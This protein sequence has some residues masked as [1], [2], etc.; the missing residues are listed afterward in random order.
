MSSRRLQLAWSAL[1]G[2]SA[3]TALAI[4]AVPRK[5]E[6]VPK[7]APRPLAEL[8][9]PP[10]VEDEPMR[11]SAPLP[12][13]ESAERSAGEPVLVAP[14]HARRVPAAVTTVPDARRA[15]VDVLE[16]ARGLAP[17]ALADAAVA[18]GPE[19]VPSLLEGILGRGQWP[20]GEH[21]PTGDLRVE[22][23]RDAWSRYEPA[24]RARALV[25]CSAATRDERRVLVEL[26]GELGGELALRTVLR[27]AREFDG[28]DLARAF[29]C[30][31]VERALALAL[32]S[33]R[34]GERQLEPM[35][36]ELP[37][38]LASA[39]VRAWSLSGDMRG[40]ALAARALGHDAALDLEIL[41]ALAQPAC[42]ARAA[43]GER[44]LEGLRG[45]LR[46]ADPRL[47]RCA[48]A[49]LGNARD[50]RSVEVLV[51]TL[52]DVD[53]LVRGAARESLRAITGRDLG[54]DAQAWDSWSAERREWLEVVQPRELERSRGSDCGAAMEALEALLA[55]AD[56][57]DELVSGL[58]PL[59]EGSA[60]ENV[61]ERV[62]SALLDIG[63][64]RALALAQR[65]EK[66][67]VGTD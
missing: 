22:A 17:S 3:F 20:E 61:A 14:V 27:L 28:A 18:L 51:A 26:A 36:E 19:L 64:A 15:L 33:S 4:V 35:L 54:G 12:A 1:V 16:G 32:G 57:R 34:A 13:V 38:P 50:T 39:L 7:P 29:V 66:P 53:A 24:L 5:G 56:T 52:E 40:P 47:R 46:H 31:P 9:A 62:R 48:A 59:L 42:P 67:G 30:E 43:L 49:A 55:R 65:V 8:V 23:L 63:S 2:A 10:P 45:S 21:A 41:T 58:A 37:A 11:D 6:S 60:C 25:E 44:A